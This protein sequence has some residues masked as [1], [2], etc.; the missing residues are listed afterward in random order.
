MKRV[1]H[2]YLFI[3]S[4]AITIILNSTCFA[5]KND[6]DN[7]RMLFN[8]NTIK[9]SDNTRLLEVSFIAKNKKNRKDKVPIYNA[10]IKFF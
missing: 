9:Q 2:K 6:T 5:Q 7:Y 8:F 4:L 10:E 1:L 3:T